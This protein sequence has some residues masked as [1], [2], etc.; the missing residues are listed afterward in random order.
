MRK[1]LFAILGCFILFAAVLVGGPVSSGAVL[2]LLPSLQRPVPHDLPDDY[3]PLHKGG[4]DMSTGTYVRENEDLVVRGTPALI[5]R[6]TYIAGYRVSKQFGIGASHDGERY[7]HGD[8][9]RFQ[10][11]ELIHANGSRIAFRRTSPGTSF[12]NAMYRHWATPSEWQGA[13]LGWTGGSWAARRRDGTLERFQACGPNGPKTCSIVEWRD[14]DGHTIHY[15]RDPAG[16]LLRMIADSRWIAF[17]YDAADRIVRAHAS[18]GAAVHY[19]YDARGRLA[20]ASASDGTV[21]RYTYTERDELATVDE[22]D[23]TL[24]NFY[25]ANGRCVRQINRF[26]DGSEPLT[27]VFAYELEDGAVVRT[28][29]SR[30]EGSWTAYTWGA[31]RYSTSETR[32][33]GGVQLV[34]FTYERDPATNA[35]A[36]LT[37]TCPDRRGRPLK[38]T[39]LVRDSVDRVKWDLLQTH[40]SFAE[41]PRT[42]IDPK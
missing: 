5:L 37:L 32:G 42:P 19:G 9:Q 26:R 11:V 29:S 4:A 33:V 39:S 15:Q 14:P 30:S 41:W 28:T 27:F 3:V 10:W 1:I 20:R 8:G 31:G 13:R 22:P 16:R 38:H 25:D 6:R 7:L 2:L 34:A 36:S 18:T 35:I 40:C 21:R 12:L 17:D 23:A 24:E